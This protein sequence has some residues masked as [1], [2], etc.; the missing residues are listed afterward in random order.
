ME[1]TEPNLWPEPGGR[2]G[3]ARL[4][5]TRSPRNVRINV[6]LCPQALG[7]PVRWHYFGDKSYDPP[8]PMRKKGYVTWSSS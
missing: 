1:Q 7:S 8:F 4:Q 5:L 6:A 2:A 3:P